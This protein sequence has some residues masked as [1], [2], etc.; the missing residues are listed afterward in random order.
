MTNSVLTGVDTGSQLRS[1]ALSTN[2][3]ELVSTHRYSQNQIIV[4]KYPSLSQVAMLTGHS[5]R[6]SYLAVSPSGETI[7][8]RAGDETL[9]FWN[10]FRERRG[11]EEML[12]I[13]PCSCHRACISSD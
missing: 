12:R 9:G 3:N 1:L 8:T 7:V 13:S 10:V 11:R 4:W 2:V 6:V 5:Q